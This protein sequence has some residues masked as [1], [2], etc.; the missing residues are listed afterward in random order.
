MRSARWI[1][2]TIAALVLAALPHKGLPAVASAASGEPVTPSH[3]RHGALAIPKSVQV[4]HEAIHAALVE[5]TRAPGRVGAAANELAK[6]LHPHFVREEQIA[7]PPLGLLAPLA[8]G[9]RQVEAMSIALEMSQSLQAEL[10]K[11]LEEHVKIR[12]AVEALKMAAQ[13][14][15][16]IEAERLAEELA[17]HAKTEEEVL[18]PAAILVGM[19]IRRVLAEK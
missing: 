3:E 10:P 18:Y 1:T 17:L 2:T 6:V 12:A 4:E 19:E 7:L 11:M 14:E 5:A 8:A 13:A 15:G 9:E 16:A